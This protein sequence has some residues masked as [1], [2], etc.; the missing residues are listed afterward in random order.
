[1]SK[2]SEIRKYLEEKVDP[3][4]KPLL[5]DLMKN[6]PGEVYDYMKNWV[7]VKGKAINDNIHQKQEIE[8]SKHY[9]E[10]KNSIIPEQNP[11]KSV[12][13]IKQESIH[14]IQASHHDQPIHESN[15]EIKQSQHELSH[16]S[17]Q[18]EH[19]HAAHDDT[20]SI[21]HAHEG[22]DQPHDH[23]TENSEPVQEN[24][25][26]QEAQEYKEES[27]PERHGAI[28][29]EDHEASAPEHNESQVQNESAVKEPNEVPFQA[30]PESAV[31][32]NLEAPVQ[33]QQEVPAN[34]SHH[35]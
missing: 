17:A 5:L 21:T 22:G 33:E 7:E 35:E 12:H 15:H 3:F 23:Q 20:P 8:Q 18:V 24:V 13:D 31:K 9:E 26:P 29:Q 10:I 28:D 19:T 4:L 25:K 1:M 30:L 34:E 2:E 27:V 14:E 16:V 6:R 11:V 32:E